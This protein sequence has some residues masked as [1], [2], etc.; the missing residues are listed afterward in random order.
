MIKWWDIYNAVR[1]FVLSFT[2]YLQWVCYAPGTMLST[3][4]NEVKHYKC[5]AFQA[6]HKYPSFSLPLSLVTPPE[7]PQGEASRTGSWIQ[8]L[9]LYNNLMKCSKTPLM[10][11]WSLEFWGGRSYLFEQRAWQMKNLG[12][13]LNLNLH[14]VCFHVVCFYLKPMLLRFDLHIYTDMQPFEGYG[15]VSFPKCV[16]PG[17]HHHNQTE[18]IFNA[19]KSFLFSFVFNSPPTPTPGNRPSTFF[20][21]Q[22]ALPFQ[23]F[24]RI[25][26][27]SM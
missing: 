16:H 10:G 17:N 15:L 26:S 23:W 9:L 25:G 21:F 1:S 12:E 24:H 3:W 7:I 6:I 8:S 20:H 19:S 14:S 13:F 5:E 4:C 11:K 27:H 18:S 2:K 22:F